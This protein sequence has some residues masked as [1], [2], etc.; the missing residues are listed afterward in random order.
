V[1]TGPI[2]GGRGGRRAA[3]L[4]LIGALTAF[5]P[6]PAARSADAQA[7]ITVVDT[8]RHPVLGLSAEDFAMRDGAVRQPVL[9]VEPAAAPLSVAVVVDGF[10]AG[11]AADVT[12]AVVGLTRAFAAVDPRH[13]VVMSAAAAGGRS[14][15]ER[16]LDACQSLR[17]ASTDRRV[18]LAIARRGPGDGAVSDPA[19]LSDAI[20]VGKVALWTIEVGPARTTP[21]DK[22]LAES[23]DLGGA[24]REMVPATS[25]MRAAASRVASLL[26]SQYLVTYAW[27]NPMLSRVDIS[28]RHDRGLVLAPIWTR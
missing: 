7:Y 1:E 25:A 3:T 21:L 14:F 22:L 10:E 16:L 5:V 24:L 26:L 8:D 11:D 12:A 6:A 20:L 2:H 13:Q 19:R 23:S 28:I 27:P 17:S 4:A 9:D 18:V 15:V